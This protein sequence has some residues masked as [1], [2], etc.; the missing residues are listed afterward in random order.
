MDYS[1]IALAEW[2]RFCLEVTEWDRERYLR[3]V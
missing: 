2:D 3:L 1:T